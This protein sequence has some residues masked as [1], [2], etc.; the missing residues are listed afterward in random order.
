MCL[1]CSAHSLRGSGPQHGLGTPVRCGHTHCI[2]CSPNPSPLGRLRAPWWTWLAGQEGAQAL[3]CQTPMQRVSAGAL[4]FVEALWDTGHFPEHYRTGQATT[5][6]WPQK[7]SKNRLQPSPISI[8]WGQ[9]SGQLPLNSG[10]H[11][12]QRAGH[13]DSTGTG[14]FWLLAP[15][16]CLTN[17]GTVWGGSVPRCLPGPGPLPSA[18][19]GAAPA[20]PCVPGP[21]F[22]LDRERYL[23]GLCPESP[24]GGAAPPW[25]SSILRLEPTCP[26]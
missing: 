4:P 25:A 19:S 14:H 6:P 10:P 3:H 12:P 9:A 24:R 5:S 1:F 21:C 8:R 20:A 2:P 16:R 17:S 15:H 18:I 26:S 13:S 22:Q 11:P 7:L 23:C